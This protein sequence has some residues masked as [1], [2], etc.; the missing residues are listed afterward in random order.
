MN[1]FWQ[2]NK[3]VKKVINQAL[4]EN[5]EF[6]IVAY[7]PHNGYF[8]P[9]HYSE[10]GWFSIQNK[11]IICFKKDAFQ[12]LFPILKKYH[13]TLI[14]GQDSLQKNNLY[15][16]D[17]FQEINS[18]YLKA[19][20]AKSSKKFNLEAF[21]QQEA[22]WMNAQKNYD[23]KYPDLFREDTLSKL[24][25][26]FENTKNYLKQTNSNVTVSRI[27]GISH[28]ISF[29]PPKQNTKTFSKLNNM[30]YRSVAFIFSNSEYLPQGFYHSESTASRP[31]NWSRKDKIS[32]QYKNNPDEFSFYA[33]VG[34][35]EIFSK[36]SV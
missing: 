15:G 3:F 19:Y 4:Q 25:N 14:E 1:T 10:L 17:I 28:K 13:P 6:E 11:Y 27:S 32:T 24:Y 7:S 21:T 30:S 18:F 33:H 5:V 9:V 22:L 16:Y 8:M 34:I 12:K 23:N 26:T 20:L 2:L 29:T 35:F 31:I 36:I